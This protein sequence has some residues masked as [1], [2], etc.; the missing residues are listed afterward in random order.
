MT[1]KVGDIVSHKV[2]SK[3][4]YLI[5]EIEG[6][7]V[8]LVG[9]TS[10]S[11]NGSAISTQT[12]NRTTAGSWPFSSWT[13]I[14]PPRDKKENLYEKI[15]YLAKKKELLC[16]EKATLLKQ[17]DVPSAETMGETGLGITSLSTATDTAIATRVGTSHLQTNQAILR[18][19]LERYAAN[20]IAFGLPLLA[21]PSLEL[22]SRG[23]NH[24]V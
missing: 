24:T 23:L 12:F 15:A 3:G 1:F 13:L 11:E 10:F 7:F 22:D 14:S 5:K 4:V 6:E 16:Q 18:E 20:Q 2:D 17:V 19:L 9:W 8:T 21:F